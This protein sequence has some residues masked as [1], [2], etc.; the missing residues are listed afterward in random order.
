[1]VIGVGILLGRFSTVGNNVLQGVEGHGTIQ[2]LG[3]I[4]TISWTV[5]TAEY[6]HGFTVGLVPVP[7]T[8]LL[9]G[10]GLLG[11]ALLRGRKLFKG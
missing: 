8:A 7:P 11:L 9:L 2:F 3:T 1:M 4:S 10:S 6:W 5:P